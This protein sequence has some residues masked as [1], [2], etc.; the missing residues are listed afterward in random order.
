MELM[1]HSSWATWGLVSGQDNGS[2]GSGGSGG[3]P[4][5]CLLPGWQRTR[6]E[7]ERRGSPPDVASSTVLG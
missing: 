7:L 1:S 5:S 6:G 4:S 2:S 3:S